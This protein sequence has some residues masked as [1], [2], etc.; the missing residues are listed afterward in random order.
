M[1]KIIGWISIHRKIQDCSIWDNEDPFDMRS[2]W[3]DLLLMANHEDKRIIFDGKGIVVKRGQ[4]LTSFRKLS[5]RWH[6]SINRTRR[7]I[8]LLE[9]EGMITRKSDSR[10]TLLTVVNYDLYQNPQTVTDTVP[11]TLTDT[12]TDTLTIQSRIHSRHTNNNDNNINNENNENNEKKKKGTPRQTYG[13]YKH[14]KLTEEE[15]NRLCNDYGETDTLKAIK[16]LDEYCQETGKTYKDYNLTLRRWPIEE[17]QKEKPKQDHKDD[18]IS[19]WLNRRK[20]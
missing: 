17:A 8:E 14:V 3:I 15:F 11:D 18:V 19:Q 16:I 10:S 1:G 12:E 13:E 7:Y 6:W 20:T 5:E 2:A 9:G 4:R